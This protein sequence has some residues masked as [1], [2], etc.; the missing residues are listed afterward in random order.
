MI[1]LVVYL[2]AEGRQ[3]FSAWFDGLD[4]HAAAKVTAALQRMAAG[5][6]SDAKSVGA[7]VVER[8]ID[9]GP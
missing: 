3:P 7:G 8:R 9:W 4:V 5:N 2:D 1:E 6:F